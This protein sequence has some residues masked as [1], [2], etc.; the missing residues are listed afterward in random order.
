MRFTRLSPDQE[1]SLARNQ[2]IPLLPAYLPQLNVE[3]DFW[4]ARYE[5]MD[6]QHPEHEFT[7]LIAEDLTL[8]AAVAL[9]L[10]SENREARRKRSLETKKSI[11]ITRQHAIGALGLSR[12][13]RIIL[14][15]EQQS[16]KASGWRLPSFLTRKS[17]SKQPARVLI[18][19]A[20]ESMGQP[21]PR[22]MHIEPV[23]LQDLMPPL[24]GEA[25]WYETEDMHGKLYVHRTAIAEPSKDFAFQLVT[26]GHR[27]DFDGLQTLYPTLPAVK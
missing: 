26:E 14:S 4:I 24:E 21:E 27:V 10:A 25:G 1:P 9:S 16:P 2:S 20:N 13:S 17:A 22:R 12:L 18:E 23:L 6:E 8:N 11:D 7:Y 15:E 5:E 3:K 19:P